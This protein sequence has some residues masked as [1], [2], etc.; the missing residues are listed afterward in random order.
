MNDGHVKSIVADL[1]SFNFNCAVRKEEEK[2]ILLVGLN[3]QERILAEAEKQLIMVYRNT[4][5]KEKDAKRK[6]KL[7]QQK[8]YLTK[9]TIDCEQKKPFCLARRNEF[10]EGEFDQILNESTKS[11]L[12]YIILDKIRVTDM[13]NTLKAFDTK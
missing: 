8:S 4:L 10:Y 7:I 2:H 9:N 6:A 3:D 11:R 13:K 1:E 12:I 5:D